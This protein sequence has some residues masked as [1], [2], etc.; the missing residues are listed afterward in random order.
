MPTVL[1]PSRRGNIRPDAVEDFVLL[2]NQDLGLGF[3]E[4]TEAEDK[5]VNTDKHLI[6]KFLDHGGG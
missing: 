5:G 6:W 2:S 1:L 3:S 4:T